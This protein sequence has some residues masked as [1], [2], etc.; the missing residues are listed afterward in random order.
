MA[1][2]LIL[3]GIRCRLVPED[4][5]DRLVSGRTAEQEADL[6]PLPEP[7]PDGLYPAL[8]YMDASLA[9]RLIRARRRVDLSQAELARRAG[10]RAETLNRIDEV[11]SAPAS[12]RSRRSAARSGRPRP[13]SRQLASRA[14]RR[15]AGG[16]LRRRVG[17]PG[18]VRATPFSSTMLFSVSVSPRS[19][20]YCHCPGL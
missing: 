3:D 1:G 19:V 14:G 9:R 5:Y 15:R 11:K 4:E 12:P 8:E 20:V 17:L 7:R 2:I 10:I 18:P 16:D 13:A 6:P